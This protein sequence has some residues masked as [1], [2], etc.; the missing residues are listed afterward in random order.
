MKQFYLGLHKPAKIGDPRLAGRAVFLCRNSIGGRKVLRP[1]APGASYAVDLGGFTEL[2]Q[3]GRWVATVDECVDLLD[4]LWEQVG[5]YDFAAHRDMMCEPAVIAGGT[6][7]GVTFAGTGLSVREHQRWT[8]EDF[9]VMRARARRIAP[10]L[11]GWT[12]AEYVECARMY[13]AAGVDLTREPVVLLG[14]MCRREATADAER[15]IRTLYDMGLVNLHGL[16]FKV[17]GL[18][19]CWRWLKTADSMAWSFNARYARTPCPH[20][21]EWRWPDRQPI[22]C[23]NCLAYALEWSQPFYDRLWEQLPTSV[24]SW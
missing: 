24:T 19:N 13:A 6:W 14:S 16:G 1:I 4:Q 2:Q 8:V 18:R 15:I 17:A 5:P 11:Q 9:L 7:K 3:R 10:A 22:S 21:A 20:R 12:L 23:G